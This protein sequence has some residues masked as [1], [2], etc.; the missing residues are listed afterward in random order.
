MNL[1]WAGQRRVR[2]GKMKSQ[3][4]TNLVEQAL[5]I[6][7]LC[8]IMFGIIDCAR[9]M[10]A[11]HFVA[12]AAREA[13][14][15]ASVRS[16]SS[17]IGVNNG[18][19]QTMVRN[20]PGMGLDSNKLSTTTNYLAPPHGSPSCPGGPASNKPGC[21]VQVQV[22]YN[23]SFILPLLPTGGVTMKSTSETL[24]TQ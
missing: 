17:G 9:L 12:N 13:A 4:G 16:A 20:V 24:I 22:T 6:T 5:T 3:R 23:Y 1:R 7:F 2:G 8:S 15:Y 18:T 21:M 14:R 19:L 10:Y 11:Y